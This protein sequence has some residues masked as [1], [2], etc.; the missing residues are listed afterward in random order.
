MR[1]NPQE[2]GQALF[3]VY[4]N[5]GS[6][7]GPNQV[8]L[9]LSSNMFRVDVGANSVYYVHFQPSPYTNDPL[10]VIRGHIIDGTWNA[11]IN[12][13]RVM[14]RP[15][16]S[17]TWGG[18]GDNLNIGT[19]YKTPLNDGQPANQGDHYYHGL[20]TSAT[21]NRWLIATITN[22]PDHQV[23]N[24][25]EFEPID[26]YFHWMTRWYITDWGPGRLS[27]GNAD[28]NMDLGPIVLYYEPDSD[29]EIGTVA[30]HHSGTQYRLQWHGKQD[31]EVTYDVRVRYDGQ[32]MRVNGF[33]SG[34]FVGTGS[35][36]GDDYRT[37]ALNWTA[38]ESTNGAYVAIREQG[39]TLFR[40]E[41]LPYNLSPTNLGLVGV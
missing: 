7:A 17:W 9:G 2:S 10:S 38:P 15:T 25:G 28:Y 30:L 14:Y 35:T 29:P 32:S 21:A 26:D 19:Y 18:A 37:V 13:M 20:G 22:K 36:R 41:F 27:N 16:I 5:A 34:T 8:Y 6:H 12:R 24:P 11:Q 3:R 23:G 33:E 31:V 39:N 4:N 1:N 40:E